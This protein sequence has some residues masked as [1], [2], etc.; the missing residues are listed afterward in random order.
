MKRKVFYLTLFLFIWLLF[1]NYSLVLSTTIDAV[2]LWLYKVFPY[3]FIM[4]IVNDL[5]LQADF[6]SF[7]KTSY[8][9]VFFMSILSGTPTSAFITKELLQKGN[10]SEKD[11]NFILIFTYFCN[12]LFLFSFFQLLFQNTF[13][14]IKLMLI[15]YFSNALLLFYYKRFIHSST[16]HKHKINLNLSSS[17]SKAMTT[18]TMVLG[19]IVFYMVLSNII[20]A[21]V[22]LN[23][24]IESLFKGFLEVTQ[25]LNNIVTINV[26]SKLKEM[27]ALAFISFGG[28]SIHTQILCILENTSLKY[29]FFL[30]GRILGTILALSMYMI[31]CSLG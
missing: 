28:L 20:L 30:K 8:F 2:D 11:A 18:T 1:K 3:L 13:I 23:S 15:H 6:A 14:S 12:P 29:S 7:F 21:S 5:L 31:L 27:I 9:Y 10:I 22:P 25:G 4:I 26:T 17:I 16:I 24:T 19:V